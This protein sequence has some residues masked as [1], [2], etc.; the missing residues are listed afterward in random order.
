MKIIK[1]LASIAVLMVGV[2]SLAGCLSDSSSS[3]SFTQ[4]DLQNILETE[5]QK[6]ASENKLSGGG[7]A[8]QIL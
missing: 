5:W 2:L 7:L 1:F 6:F 3:P 4:A 8:M